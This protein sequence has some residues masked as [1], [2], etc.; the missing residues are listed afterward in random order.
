VL[1]TESVDVID[2]LESLSLGKTFLE[3]K[4][5]KGKTISLKALIVL[6]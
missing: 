6:P 4:T 2:K 3:G 1:E 5:I